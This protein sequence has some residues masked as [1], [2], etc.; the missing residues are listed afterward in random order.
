MLSTIDIAKHLGVSQPR[1]VQLCQLGCPKNSLRAVDRWRQERGQ[2]RAPT[3][4]GCKF[5]DEPDEP[6]GKGRPKAPR[7]PAKTGNSLLDA[8]SNAIAV[9]DG[10]FE[11]Y[12]FARRN[13]LGSR[14]VRLAEHNKALDSRLKAEKAYREEVERRKLIV[15]LQEAMDMC[16]RTM[17]P[18]LRR[19]KKIPSEVGPQCNPQDPLM[20]SKILEGEVNAVIAVGRKA[21]DA[22]KS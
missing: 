14:S 8:L 9:A 22:L 15:P 21:L 1:A 3:N 4:K 10:A 20:A 2:K 19:L 7:A 17:E 13:K 11:D 16:R 6:T 5:A 18:V 12:D